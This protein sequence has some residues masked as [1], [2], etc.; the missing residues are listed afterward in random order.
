[1]FLG[2]GHCGLVAAVVN[3]G[4]WSCVWNVLD[5]N[6]CSYI[7]SIL[8]KGSNRGCL[9]FWFCWCRSLSSS[10]GIFWMKR[11]NWIGVMGVGILESLGVCLLDSSRKSSLS[12]FVNWVFWF[13]LDSGNQRGWFRDLSSWCWVACILSGSYWSSSLQSWWYNWEWIVRNKAMNSFSIRLLNNTGKTSFTSVISA[14]LWFGWCSWSSLS[15]LSLS[16]LSFWLGGRDLFCFILLGVA[17]LNLRDWWLLSSSWFCFAIRLCSWCLLLLLQSLSLRFGF[18]VLFMMFLSLF[19]VPHFN[20]LHRHS[21]S[22][23]LDLLLFM[24]LLLLLLLDL[25]L[26]F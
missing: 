2:C 11:H 6:S 12:S 9:R 13:D 16:F 20:L 18:T 21:K 7:W 8:S 22:L 5:M 1:M 14:H 3:L 19:P 26:L 10:P 25:F 17:D 23:I 15:S 4:K 24:V